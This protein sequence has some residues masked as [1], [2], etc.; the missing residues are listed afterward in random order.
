[1]SI[2]ESRLQWF[3]ENRTWKLN[4]VVELD[5]TPAAQLVP[6]RN[7]SCNTF[8]V[9]PLLG[10]TLPE[11]LLTD[12]SSRDLMANDRIEVT[13]CFDGRRMAA[14][15]SYRF[16]G[17]PHPIVYDRYVNSWVFPTKSETKELPPDVTRCC[18]PYW[19]NIEFKRRRLA[20]HLTHGD[21]RLPW[22]L[23]VNE[24]C[25]AE[26]VQGGS[27]RPTLYSLKSRSQ[28]INR[29]FLESELPFVGVLDCKPLALQFRDVVATEVTQ[30]DAGEFT[31]NTNL[32]PFAYATRLELFKSRMMR[33]LGREPASMERSYDS[34]PNTRFE[35]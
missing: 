18:T 1:M 23:W 22:Q 21:S 30:L 19:K 8:R 34:P 35:A 32:I 28:I 14:M 9:L 20:Y 24:E 17:R 11:E 29:E 26:L 25:V 33:L 16:E 4:W 27:D 6:V 7:D 10:N 2:N 3:C 12:T 31:L 15:W 5:H 13:N